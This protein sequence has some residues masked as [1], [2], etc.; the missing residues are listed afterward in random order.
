MAEDNK[1]VALETIVTKAIQVPG[2]KVNR[3]EFL[4]S[5]FKDASSDKMSRILDVGPVVAGYSRKQLLKKAQ[6]IL[7]KRTLASTGASFAAGL[8]GGFA[9][10]ATIPA[11]L[12]QFYAI[13]LRLAQEISYIYG[14]P[15]LWEEGALCEERVS[16][17]LI[18]FCGVMLG[19][20][21]ASAAIRVLSSAL[22]KQALKKIPQKALTKTIYY[23]IVKS[24]CKYFGIK[25]TK[26]VFAKSVSKTVPIIGG[27]A[28]GILTFAS[29]KPMGKRLIEAF[30]E[31]KFDYSKDEFHAD[32]EE[33][34]DIRD[35]VNAPIDVEYETVDAPKV[36]TKD[37]AATLR[38]YKSLLDDGIISSEDFEKLKNDIIHRKTN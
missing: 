23:P 10:A 21:G 7:N 8:P 20:N 2:V 31:A 22:G 33:I 4:C 29:M 6:D 15:D 19:V 12:L 3:R 30:D 28:S 26:N 27:F 37:I 24:I 9:M 11:D 5:V 18:L 16:N 32:W 14:E 1:S 13:A 36:S 25:M 17:Q 35:G 38:E 34:G